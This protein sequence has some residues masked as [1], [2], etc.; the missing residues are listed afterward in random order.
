MFGSSLFRKRSSR[1]R[2]PPL[3]SET[4]MFIL[5]SG[6]TPTGLS[7]SALYIAMELTD[8]SYFVLAT[9]SLPRPTSE[10]LIV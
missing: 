2:W 4:G 1:L 7:S 6:F 5:K 9:F 3:E 10:R 8:G